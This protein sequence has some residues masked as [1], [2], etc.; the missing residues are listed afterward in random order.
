MRLKKAIERTTSYP[1][2]ESIKPILL[3]LSVTIAL[4]ACSTPPRIAK[5]IPAPV[6]EPSTA[7]DE[8]KKDEVPV[9]AEVAGGIPADIIPPNPNDN[10][11]PSNFKKKLIKE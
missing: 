10:E 11:A 8:V 6:S 9:P 4:S 3:S 5:A 7:I 2:K 1:T